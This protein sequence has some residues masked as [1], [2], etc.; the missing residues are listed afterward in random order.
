MAALVA[1]YVLLEVGEV[2]AMLGRVVSPP[3]VAD[4]PDTGAVLPPLAPP[5]PQD[6]VKQQI[7]R[8]RV[9]GPERR[10]V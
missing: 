6:A 9:R 1:A 10:Q 7:A 3:P 5:P 8:N 4:E 2:M